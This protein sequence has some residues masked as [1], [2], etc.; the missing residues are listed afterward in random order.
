M[1]TEKTTLQKIMEQKADQIRI[2]IEEAIDKGAK[3]EKSF[4]NCA[5][6]DDVFLQKNVNTSQFAV[7]LRFD[8]EKIAKVFEPNLQ[9]LREQAEQKLEELQILNKQIEEIEKNETRN[10]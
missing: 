3:I 10:Y 4:T 6:I 1:D 7:V 8:S 5:T 2:A 9:E